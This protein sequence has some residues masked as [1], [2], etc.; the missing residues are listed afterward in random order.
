MQFEGERTIALAADQIFAK[1]S[2]ARFLV[3]SIPQATVVGTPTASV[4]HCSIHPNMTGTLVV[5]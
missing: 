2:D 3:K 5:R 4:A 1:L